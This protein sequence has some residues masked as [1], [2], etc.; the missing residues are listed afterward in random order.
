M[1]KKRSLFL[2]AI[3][4]SLLSGILVS[5]AGNREL[6]PV[7]DS[8]PSGSYENA[9]SGAETKTTEMIALVHSEEEA[10]EVGKQYQIEFMS[11][12]EGVAV[13]STEKNPDELIALGKENG[14]VPLSVNKS[15]QLYN[16]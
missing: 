12:S 16:E 2:T 3:G 10:L 5:C 8:Q 11:F 6:T 1:V 13:F 15:L 14:Y 4:A 7:E 9:D